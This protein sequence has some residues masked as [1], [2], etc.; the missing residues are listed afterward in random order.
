MTGCSIY[1]KWREIDG[2][3]FDYENSGADTYEYSPQACWARNGGNGNGVWAVA[4][5][6]QERIKRDSH[7]GGTHTTL[8]LDVDSDDQGLWY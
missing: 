2:A 7:G 4:V 6:C 8:R 5:C 1:T 3:F